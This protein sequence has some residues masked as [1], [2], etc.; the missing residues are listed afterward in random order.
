MK[1]KNKASLYRFQGSPSI[2]ICLTHH[3][4]LF[5]SSLKSLN[6]LYSISFFSFY[7]LIKIH[8]NSLIIYWQ[9]ICKLLLKTHV[10]ILYLALW[11]ETAL[12]IHFHYQEKLFHYILVQSV[13]TSS[14]TNCNSK[15][16]N[17]FWYFKPWLKTFS[18]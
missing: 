1:L 8:Y 12:P 4:L 13:I 2:L 14:W 6:F 16:Q 15:N 3:I 11:C 10:P 17:F 5:D 9:Y 18:F 7:S